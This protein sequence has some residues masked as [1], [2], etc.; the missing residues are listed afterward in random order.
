MRA[1]TVSVVLIVLAVLSSG[2]VSVRADSK[3]IELRFRSDVFATQGAGEGAPGKDAGPEIVLFSKN[4]EDGL[5][6]D[7]ARQLENLKKYFR[8]PSLAA[9]K[10]TGTIVLGAPS[11]TEMK[12]N[13]PKAA[14]TVFLDGAEYSIFIIPIEI[15]DK[16]NLYRFRLEIFRNGPAANSPSLKLMERI[17]SKEVLWNYSGPLA[18]GLFSGEKTCFVTFTIDYAWSS[19]A[20]SLGV[21][22]SR[23]L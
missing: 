14:K 6:K 1:R 5:G 20:G 17:M 18:V 9:E 12:K 19:F 22:M 10:E 23:T 3:R 4:G 13:D 11:W 7:A 8:I 15:N 16:D 2:A 21:G